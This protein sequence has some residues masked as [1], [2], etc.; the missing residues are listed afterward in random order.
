MRK[1]VALATASFVLA[2]CTEQNAPVPATATGN[3][4]QQATCSVYGG[5]VERVCPVSIYK[6]IADPASYYGKTVAFN[7]FVFKHSDGV[8]V[9]YPNREAALS[10]NFASGVLCS[11]GKESC[12]LYVGKHADVFGVFSAQSHPDLFFKPIGTIQLAH[13]RSVRDLA[14]R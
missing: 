11:S 5:F 14:E 4:T 1:I 7:G 13:V 12:E 6:L 9:V 8:I 2:S 10:S 3:E